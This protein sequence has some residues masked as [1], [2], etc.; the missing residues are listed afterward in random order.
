LGVQHLV[1]RRRR[2]AL[3]LAGE[4]R[5][6]GFRVL[7]PAFE[8]RPVAG[9]ERCHLVE[10]EQLGVIAAPDVALA[11]VEFEYAADPLPRYPA[12]SRQ[13]L[14]VEMK[15]AAAIAHQRPARWIGEQ[16]T[17]GIDAI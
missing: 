17:K 7:A 11:V 14:I 16:V 6:K 13:R 12:A 5:R 8:A 9:G 15:F 1:H 10:K 2:R 4:Q 3:L